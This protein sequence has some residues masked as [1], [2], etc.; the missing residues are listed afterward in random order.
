[1]KRLILIVLVTSFVGCGP[2]QPPPATPQVSDA[3]ADDALVKE[4]PQQEPDRKYAY[5]GYPVSTTP[6]S[7]CTILE[8]TAYVAC[9]SELRKA[10]L[11]VAYRLF[12]VEPLPEL[13]K[14]QS[15]FKVD[16]RTESKVTHDDYTH[17]GYDRGHMAPFAAIDRLYGPQA[18]ADSTLGS[19]DEKVLVEKNSIRRYRVI[20]SHEM[21]GF[22]T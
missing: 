9:Y 1:M 3:P 17:S 7:K 15:R 16:D 22:S 18:G 5:A 11:W 19:H 14:R 13:H 20:T 10:P 2:A 12:N 21:I 8:N 6:E 4:E